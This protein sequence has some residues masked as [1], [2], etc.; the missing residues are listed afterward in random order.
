[1][2]PDKIVVEITIG[3]SGAVRCDQQVG[4]GEIGGV[5]GRK[6][7]LDRPLGQ[8]A[9][10]VF[11]SG[12]VLGG[13]YSYNLYRNTD[14]QHWYLTTYFYRQETALY[15]AMANQAL[16]YTEQSIGSFHDRIGSQ[17]L[18]NKKGDLLFWSRLMGEHRNMDSG[19][20]QTS[21]DSGAQQIGQDLWVSFEDT[22]RASFGVYAIYG[23]S[24]SDIDQ[25]NKAGK[26]AEAGTSDFDNKGLG[27]YFNRVTEN[28]T[29]F[30]AVIQATRHDLETS[31]VNEAKLDTWG[32][33]LAASLESGHA[34]DIADG[35]VLEPQAQAIFQKF[36]LKDA[37]D[38]GGLVKFDD[39]QSA[40][41]RAGL[42]LARNWGA[43][44]EERLTAWTTLNLLNSFG[45]D[46]QT[47]F[48]T[49]TGNDVVFNNSL[50][51]PRL[52]LK[53]GLEG[54][55]TQNVSLKGNIGVEQSLDN[56]GTNAISGEIGLNI[57]F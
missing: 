14:D 51:G 24:R 50:L 2:V 27:A 17:E 1:M 30:D 56:H 25:A 19:S 26:F 15:A 43:T 20:L 33:G 18:F 52:G 36:H 13:A 32:T 5:D 21:T 6:F 35:W 8:A 4:I 46:T 49:L 12:L 37:R 47:S 7:D 29:Y 22:V 48:E 9:W 28:G 31:S 23:R 16:T 3:K 41:L 57:S 44:P 55:I 39:S 53:G 45:G 38:V 40:T 34:F 54:A 11:R 10:N 42:R